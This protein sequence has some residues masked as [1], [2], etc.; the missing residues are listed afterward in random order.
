MSAASSAR[1]AYTAE[2]LDRDTL[3]VAGVVLLGAVMSI[4]DITVVNV[5]IDRLAIDFGASLTTIQWVVTAYT[6]AIAA[7]IPLTGWAADRF[8]TKR[9]YLTSLVLFVGG[10][11][12]CG[13]AWDAGSLIFFRVLQGLGGGMI[14]PAVMTIMTKKAGPSRMGRVMG[15]LG[16]PMLIAPIAGPI[17]GGW[18]VDDVSWRW[19]FFINVPIG[20]IA[21]IAAWIKLDRDQAQPTHKLD[22]L[23]MALLSPGLTLLI[24]GLAETGS[25]GFDAPRAWV[26]MAVGALLIAAFLRHSWTTKAPLIDVR[27]FTH[28]RAGAAAGVFMLFAIAMFGS[29]LLVPLYYQAVRG[30]TALQSGLLLAPQGF[31]AM[32][33]M[34]IA[35]RLT[36]RYGPTKLP[37]AGL[38][39]AAIGMLSFA[40]VTADTSYVLLGG[41][42]FVL[43]LGMGLSM[44]PTMTAAMQAVP[45]Q[46][47][48]RTS[49]AMNI[50]RQSGASIGTA[51]LSV[52]LASAIASHLSTAPG[53]SG[54][55]E[56]LHGLSPAERATVAGPLA[57]AFAATFLWGVVLLAL[58]WLPALAL[59]FM[60]GRSSAA[61]PATA[62]H[63][64]VME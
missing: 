38:P 11:V 59:A 50:I 8:G 34:P 9:L 17:L 10:S 14:M 6:L 48:A 42:S 4:L 40:F 28:T 49:T 64:I 53:T 30:D 44:M 1:P 39:L 36:D 41:F 45:P 62:E 21:F 24:F 7:V 18:L 63:A 29:L 60:H 52:I 16:V 27:T 32:I 12:L 33:T 23:G 5:A 51:I 43:G 25:H 61:A 19:I 58:A 2:P 35:G 55:F 26:P 13:L 31:G 47:I 57:D 20:C 22:W 54:G 3:V 15:V 56:S 46:A 37:A